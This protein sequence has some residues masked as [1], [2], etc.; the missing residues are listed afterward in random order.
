M[1]YQEI[2]WNFLKSK[3]LNDKSAA[4]IMG[5]IQAESGFNPDVIEH[6]TGIGFGLCQWSYGRRTELEAYGTDIEHQLNFLW[7]E[8]TGEDL[9]ITGANYQ[10][11]NQDEY[12]NHD[13]FMN[14]NG[15]IDDLTAS[16]CFSWERPSLE[17]SH[18]DD[19]KVYANNYYNEFQGTGGI[20]T[21]VKLIYPYWFGSKVKI[22]FTINKFLLVAS[23]GNVVLIKNELNK[24]L[25]YVAKSS[26]RIV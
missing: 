22:S 6:G 14:G 11:I 18:I 20:G 13:D 1:T 2:T 19:R 8:L 25:Y 26:T 4:A 7:S 9:E 24:R 21:Y 5:N 15:S 3:N 10:W 17:Y 16:F 12:L 23:H